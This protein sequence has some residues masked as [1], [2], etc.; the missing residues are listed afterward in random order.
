MC[1]SAMDEFRRMGTHCGRAESKLG[2][3]QE[4]HR[5]A[6]RLDHANR[7][8]ALAIAKTDD[9][10]DGRIGSLQYAIRS[11]TWWHCHPW[12][13]TSSDRISPSSWGCGP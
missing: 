10:K 2:E 8:S 1:L 5:L 6:G 4:E 3:S 13:S 7:I 11:L 9:L 12:M